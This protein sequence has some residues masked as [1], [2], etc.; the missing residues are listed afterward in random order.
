MP[1]PIGPDLKKFMNKKVSVTLNAGREV[2]GILKGYDL[3]MNIVLDETFEK[4]SETE[5]V[6]MGN[7]VRLI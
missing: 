1:K 3:Y 5:R 2:E 6:E 4:V 7:V